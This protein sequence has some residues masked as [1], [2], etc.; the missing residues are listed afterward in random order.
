MFEKNNADA[1]VISKRLKLPEDDRTNK[2][3][4]T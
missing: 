2:I 3:S 4:A 1:L